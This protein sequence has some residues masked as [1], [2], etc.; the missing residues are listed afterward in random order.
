MPTKR[1]KSI[2]K[3]PS[4]G[5]GKAPS[6]SVISRGFSQLVKV[7]GGYQLRIFT[8]VAEAVAL[9]VSREVAEKLFGGTEEKLGTC[10]KEEQY[11][12]ELNK[13]VVWCL[14]ATC[15]SSSQGTCILHSTDEYGEDEQNHGPHDYQDP[16]PRKGKR[17][18]RCE[19]E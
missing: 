4:R 10:F 12:P 6:L 9:G 2:V 17:F 14:D 8:S 18:Y 13:T 11:K 7:R 1:K 16:I 5:S 15:R 3:R 19:C